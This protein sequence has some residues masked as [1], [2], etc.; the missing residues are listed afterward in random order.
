MV[1]CS[2]CNAQETA[3]GIGVFINEK[4]LLCPGLKRT[5]MYKYKQIDSKFI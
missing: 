5:Y 2:E 3:Q 1:L 4:N